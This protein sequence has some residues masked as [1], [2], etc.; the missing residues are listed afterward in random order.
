MCHQ[1]LVFMKL[2]DADLPV[3]AAGRQQSCL[4]RVPAYTVDVLTMSSAHLSG[5]T[6][7]GLVGVA[8]VLLLEHPH[9]V[10][11]TGGHQGASL[12]TPATV[13]H[14]VTGILTRICRLTPLAG[15][16]HQSMS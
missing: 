2:P 11:A 7:H 16:S 8:A 6:E 10:V 4:L 13:D 1:S 5:Q 12:R 15:E 3:V 14:I 9:A